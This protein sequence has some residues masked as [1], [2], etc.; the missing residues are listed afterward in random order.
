MP[1]VE[2]SD[3]DEMELSVVLSALADNNRLAIVCAL[4]ADAE[5]AE[6]H[7]SSF[8]LPVTK[9]TLTHHF[10]V[11]RTA[12]LI[13]QV[14]RGNSNMAQLR[15]AELTA[16]FPGLIELLEAENRRRAATSSH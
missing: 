9:A 7:C 4:L 8:G 12:G 1:D 11:L 5:G 13:R 3:A 10:R 15:R 16:R 2:R 14:N 6:R